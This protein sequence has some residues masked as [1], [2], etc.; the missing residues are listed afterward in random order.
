MPKE[1][2]RKYLVLEGA[3]R[4]NRKGVLC[5]QGYLTLDAERTVR[6]RKIGSK[7]FITIKGKQ[8]GITRYEC[9]YEIPLHDAEELLK[10]ICIKPIIKKTRYKVEFKNYLWEV[11]EFMDENAGLITAEVEL[12]DDSEKPSLPDWVGKEVSDDYRYA[13]SNLVRNP[14]KNW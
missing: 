13:N 11:D 14:Y 6:V 7:G 1:I 5:C 10:D 12:S 4:S 9:E 2:E 8:E 3:W